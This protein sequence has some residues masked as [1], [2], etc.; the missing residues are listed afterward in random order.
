MTL[1]PVRS[2]GVARETVSAVE[3]VSVVDDDEPPHAPRAKA[4]SA[5]RATDLRGMKF[6]FFS[7]MSVS[8]G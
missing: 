4:P 1:V 5:A 6:I 8:V 3:T 2:A 7:Q